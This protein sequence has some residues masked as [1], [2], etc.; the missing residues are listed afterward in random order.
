MSDYC[1]REDLLLL[2]FKVLRIMLANTSKRRVALT[3]FSEMS[4]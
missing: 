3:F 4:A 2:T 1:G